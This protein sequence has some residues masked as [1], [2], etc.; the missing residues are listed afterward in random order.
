LLKNRVIFLVHNPLFRLLYIFTNLN[1]LFIWF[2]IYRSANGIS[3]IERLTFKS[4]DQ[5]W[6]PPGIII[7]PIF[8]GHY[9][10]DLA[11]AYAFSK[12]NNPYILELPSQTPPFGI[13]ILKI[14]TFLDYQNFFILYLVIS[15]LLILLTLWKMNLFLNFQNYTLAIVWIFLLS[16]GM[17]SNLDRGSLYVII[18][19]LI[20]VSLKNI[21]VKNSNYL[22]PALVALS[23]KPQLAICFFLVCL[24]DKKRFLSCLKVIVITFLINLISFLIFFN[25]SASF[26]GF[27][28]S[29]GRYVGNDANGIILDSSS[30]VASIFR[31]IEIF[32]G[33][34]FTLNLMGSI[35]YFIL[36]PGLL[37]YA[38]NLFITITDKN[39]SD[40]IILLSLSLISLFTP[41][42][43]NYTTYW[44]PI[45]FLLIL[46]NFKSI[47]VKF[48]LAQ[49]IGLSIF[50][51]GLILGISPQFW[52]I[53]SFTGDTERYVMAEV[54]SSIIIFLG[55]LLI[56]F[57]TKKRQNAA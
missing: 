24:I 41:N 36:L 44:M 21:T 31:V 17:I 6:L 3:F 2:T 27:I 32:Y 22:F 52:G 37:L 43:Y 20:Y 30:L 16:I 48:N 57:V 45:G 40:L 56:G 10:G 15:F 14:F 50:I 34:D 12:V 38:Y 28:K 5:P 25:T 51:V 4:F 42:S 7:E 29:F 39:N 1:L 9:A 26:Y 49:R 54:Y 46:I 23:F 35:S 53:L 19:P 8:G 18:A 13:L 47:T 33:T 55:I 11:L